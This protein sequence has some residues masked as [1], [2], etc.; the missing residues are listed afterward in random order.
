MNSSNDINDVL[1]RMKQEII[2]RMCFP[3]R[4][5][6]VTQPSTAAQIREHYINKKEFLEKRK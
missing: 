4:L 3:S 5:L 2:K 1:L 6:L